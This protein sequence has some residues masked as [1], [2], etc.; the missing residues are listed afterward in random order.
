MDD[1]FIS[2]ILAGAGTLM[3]TVTGYFNHRINKVNDKADDNV[4]ELDK[5]KLHV[6][7]TYAKEMTMQQSLGRLHDRIDDV[8]TDIKTILSKVK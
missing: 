1:G 2:T 5:H 3:L 7:E 6:S 8:A 4:K